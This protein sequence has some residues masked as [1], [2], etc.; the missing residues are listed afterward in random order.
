MP[1]KLSFDEL[2]ERIR[3]LEQDV[4]EFEKTKK[5]CD[6]AL[7]AERDKLEM[8]T[9]DIGAGIAIISRDYQTIW[10]NR[11]IKDIFGDV[12]GKICYKSYTRRSEVCP[13]CGVQEIFEKGKN[14]AIHEQMG[15]D[16]HGN[17]VWSQ[18]IAT[19][20][21]DSNGNIKEVLEIITPITELKRAEEALRTSE[22]N[23]RQ[24]FSADPDAIIIMDAETRE[25]VDANPS[26]L[27]LYGYAHEEICGLQAVKLSAEP[28]KSAR[29]I[30]DAVSSS[31]SNLPSKLA[32]RLHKKKNGTIFPVEITYGFYTRDN[33][34]MICLIMRD[35]TNRRQTEE[36][37]KA[38]KERLRVTLQSIGD[39]VITTDT[40]GKIT[41]INKIA[42][43]LTGWAEREVIGKPVTEVFRIVDGFSRK[44]CK[45]LV[46]E[47]IK[48]GKILNQA[49]N[50][51][52]LSKDNTEHII[53]QS[54][55]PIEANKN[56][57]IGAALV[58]SDITEKQKMEQEL[59]KVQKLES[60]GIL[61]GGI[62]HDFNN[63]L[64]AIIANLSL[65]KIYSNPNDKIFLELEEME[66][67]ALKAKDLTMQLLTFSK[68]GK[69]LK[70]AVSLS[71]LVK[72]SAL[73][74]LRGSDVRCEFSFAK[75]LWLIEADE[76]QIGQ[77]INNLVLNADQ[78]MPEGG[79]IQILAQNS[80]LKNNNRLSL[81]AGQYVRLSI[82]D[83]GVGIPKDHLVKIFDP[84]F[85]T[86]Q[87]GSG[88]GL[89]V[90]YSIINKHNGAIEVESELGMGT[91]F[92]V[93]L[94][95]LIKEEPQA[96]PSEAPLFK[97]KG[98]I[99][100]MDDEELVRNI[101][102]RLINLMGYEVSIARDGKE[103]IEIYKKAKCLNEPF[104][105]VIMD[106]TVPGGMGGKEAIEIL[107]EVDP[108]VKAIVSS[109]YSNDPV[110]A[111]YKQY[112]FR[113]AIKKPY[114]IQEMS[115]VLQLVMTG[116]EPSSKRSI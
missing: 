8:V 102:E 88:L 51:I 46:R 110:I 55:A 103:A 69:P 83:K 109:G 79:V 87:K 82:Q 38:E 14:K 2:E 12:E 15:I 80:I 50:T 24:L 45:N 63:F 94:P 70:R 62:A 17:T 92:N 52:L 91:I 10:A 23:Y 74:A 75:D 95:S 76:A 77:V 66:K 11:V 106:L 4:I 98:R 99:L 25:I 32:Y 81:K 49:D 101:V 28:E 90:A 111:N 113:G 86:K 27:A 36:A 18:I 93:Y 114:R 115:E 47:V 97:G 16:S 29:H 112:G 39:G 96:R 89:A 108:D 22:V 105:A 85:T 56:E 78:A 43:K 35:I 107:L 26:A 116:S 9:K 64:T 72:D 19:P 84:Y 68:G 58:F 61:A 42:E 41:L 30:E 65:A 37:L 6:K 13:K 7:R 57:I 60:L 20:I 73:F 40:E 67:A 21:K 3:K 34:K 59:L 104:N 54:S 33:R 31:I 100:V 71:A 48:S 1:E 5:D 44:P 53:A